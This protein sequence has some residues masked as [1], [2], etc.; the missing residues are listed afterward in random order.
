[1]LTPYFKHVSSSSS[2][3]DHLGRNFLNGLDMEFLGITV[4][5][6][7]RKNNE[8]N[9]AKSGKMDLLFGLFFKNS[10]KPY[11]IVLVNPRGGL[12]SDRVQSQVTK[13]GYHLTSYLFVFNKFV[14]CPKLVQCYV[15][16]A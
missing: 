15:K 8:P 12:V 6:M 9:R 16:M 7:S 5:K 14:R 3:N 2:V 4:G 1:M 13:V 11:V 10:E